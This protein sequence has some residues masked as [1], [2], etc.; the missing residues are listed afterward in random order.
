MIANEIIDAKVGSEQ[1]TKIYLGQDLIWPATPITYV[2]VDTQLVYSTGVR[3][4]AGVVGSQYTGNYFYATGTVRVMQGRVVIRTL[5]DEPLTLSVSSQDFHVLHE[6]GISHDIIRGNNLGT[7]VTSEIKSAEVMVSYRG[8]TPESAGYVEQII[9]SYTEVPHEWTEYDPEPTIAPAPVP[10]TAAVSLYITQYTSSA[11]AQ[12]CPAYGGFAY[13]YAY[14]SHDEANFSTTGWATL[15]NY[16]RT[17]TSGASETS[18]PVIIAQ[19][20]TPPVQVGNAYPVDDTPAMS[21]LPSWLH[22]SDNTLTFDS[23]GTTRYDNGRSA[24]IVVSNLDATPASVTVYQ[25]QNVPEADYQYDIVFGDSYITAENSNYYVSASANNYASLAAAAPASGNVYALITVTARHTVVDVTHTPYEI[26]E[27]PH[28]VWTSGE[29]TYGTRHL[30]EEGEDETYG[31]PRTATDTGLTPTIVMSEDNGATAFT[32]DGANS[33]VYIPTEA[34]YVYSNGRNGVVTFTNGTATDSVTLYQGLNVASAWNY[35]YD[36]TVAIDW[37][38][39]IPQEGGTFPV[40]YTSRRSGIRTYTSLA[41]ETITNESVTASVSGN[42]T[43]T[44]D[45]AT[46]SGVGTFGIS[47]DENTTPNYEVRVTLSVDGHTASDTREQESTTI[48][49]NIADDGVRYNAP[50]YTALQVFWSVANAYA[51]QGF[52]IAAELGDDTPEKGL[53]IRDATTGGTMTFNLAD[54]FPHTLFIPGSE[55]TFTIKIYDNSVS[56][57]GNIKFSKDFTLTYQ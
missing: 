19:G 7:T 23:E 55:N 24:T 26:Y 44:P 11:E 35:T 53:I 13:I 5:Y 43:C 47:V 49:F 31:T 42:G 54:D 20:T 51:S 18:T 21:N 27:T 57:H 10:N 8:S 2:L 37:V 16:T 4:D 1:V 48:T 46:V 6:Q 52:S 12:R 17:Y 9:N 25:Q 45:V 22:I 36:L 30:S 38:G 14:A 28:W 15:R 33:R 3:L 34:T 50:S 41:T 56:T 40:N 29:E 39:N 32:W